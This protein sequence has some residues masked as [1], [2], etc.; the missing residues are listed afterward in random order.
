[1]FESNR[2]DHSEI[3]TMD[4]PPAANVGIHRYANA[5]M[6]FVRGKFATG[7]CYF[8][9]FAETHRPIVSLPDTI[10]ILWHI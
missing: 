6:E 8:Q 9:A 3:S 2:A 7:H 4:G 5:P 1:M 10:T